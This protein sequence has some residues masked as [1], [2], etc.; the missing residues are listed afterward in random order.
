MYK[1]DIINFTTAHE[2]GHALLHDKLVLHR[3]LPL[4]GSETERIRSV[5]EI[6]ADKFAAM[7]LM[8]KKIV[9]Q[10][11]YELFQ[12]NKFTI[13]EETALLLTNSS[14]YELRRKIKTKRDLSRLITKCEFYNY[15]PFNS[16]SKIFQVSVEAM[17]IRLEE[18]G[19]VEIY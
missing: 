10:L 14:A 3:D 15:R 13:N 11:F 19:L 2:L 1:S 18:L 9:V 16:L 5:E 12:T 8:P 6:Q 7:F 17:S 4:D